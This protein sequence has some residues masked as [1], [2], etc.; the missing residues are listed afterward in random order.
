[1]EILKEKLA[2]IS[3]GRVLDVGTG[4]GDFISIFLGCFKD[5]SQI[6]GIDTKEGAL[7]IARDNY[8]EEDIEFINMD[9]SSMSFED[10]SMDTV[11]ISNTLHHLPHMKVVLNE[12]MRV[13]KP[14]GL[15][16]VNEMFC[17]EQSEKQLSHVYVHHLGAQIDSLL[18]VCHNNTFKKQEILDIVKGLGLKIE[19]VIE[20]NT[21]EEQQDEGNQEDEKE[22]LDD[23]FTSL[24]KRIEEI[25]GFLQYEEL[26]VKLN[27]L[28]GFLYNVGILGA[29]ELMVIGIK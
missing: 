8:K 3:G 6:I 18:G 20:Y 29:T 11:V 14:G 10:N 5:Y 13:L 25:K 4:R 1:M 22:T 26:K 7:Q 28:K 17:D 2:Q 23:I 15:F 16:I 9:A 24:D 21:Q 27:E 19:E 12:M